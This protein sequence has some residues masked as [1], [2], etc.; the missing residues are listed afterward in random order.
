ME[1]SSGKVDAYE[2]IGVFDLLSIRIGRL[3][4]SRFAVGQGENWDDHPSIDWRSI[5]L[6]FGFAGWAEHRFAKPAFWK[7]F[8]DCFWQTAISKPLQY[9]LPLLSPQVVTSGDSDGYGF[10]Q[11][12][13][14]IKECL[15]TFPQNGAGNVLE[16]QMAIDTGFAD[17]YFLV[18]GQHAKLQ[19]AVGQLFLH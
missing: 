11:L 18:G 3:R 9:L 7:R 5:C 16:H 14:F 1:S 2:F 8:V 13:G 19:I 4:Q 15:R 10:D 6:H 12:I 17:G